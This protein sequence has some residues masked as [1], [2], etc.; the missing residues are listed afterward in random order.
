[1]ENE[2]KKDFTTSDLYLAAAISLLIKTLPEYRIDEPG[3][4]VFC[5][6]KSPELYEAIASYSDG[7]KLNA[8]EFA[9]RIKRVRA[10]MLIRKNELTEEGKQG[11]RS[12]GQGA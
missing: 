3:K 4:V 7:V 5:F 9:F 11:A 6:L 12:D 8:Y 2:G 1:M 10:D